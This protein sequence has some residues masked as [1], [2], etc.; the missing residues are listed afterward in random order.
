MSFRLGVL[1]LFAITAVPI[2]FFSQTGK[3]LPEAK[4]V[5][6]PLEE[7]VKRLT[8]EVA[9]LK[10]RLSRIDKELRTNL[11]T[12]GTHQVV[13]YPDDPNY[14]L[15]LNQSSDHNTGIKFTTDSG[16]TLS[17]AISASPTAGIALMNKDQSAGSWLLVGNP[18]GVYGADIVAHAP[19][20]RVGY[21]TDSTIQLIYG[22]TADHPDPPG[23]QAYMW[24]ART[25]GVWKLLVRYNDGGIMRNGEV[26]LY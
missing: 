9:L 21:G 18:G 24:I 14:Q 7:E 16:N 26:I 10:N 22:Y 13:I 25:D 19:T 4:R 2:Q 6:A 1:F 15:Q 8:S 23:G 11:E 20:L 5:S 17:G 3:G 12:E